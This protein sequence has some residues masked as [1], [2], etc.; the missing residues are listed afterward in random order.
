MTTPSVANDRPVLV[1]GA[2]IMGSGIAQVAAQA[3]HPVWL[4]DA[5]AG[6][7]VDACRRLGASLQALVE[8]GR[9]STD[10]AAGIIERIRPIEHLAEAA[11][12]DWVIEAIVED[13]DAK[14][15]LMR[16][17]ESVVGPHCVLATK[18]AIGEGHVAQGAQRECRVGIGRIEHLV[19]T[20]PCRSEHV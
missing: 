18:E 11:Q 20:G 16:S 14:R 12:A 4:H 2:G 1:V 6:A 8:R 3:G 15:E 17:L 19:A 10:T 7:A 13:L 5:R 9:M